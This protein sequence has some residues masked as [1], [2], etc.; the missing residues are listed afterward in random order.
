[1]ERERP[2]EIPKGIEE[3]AE[4]ELIE[5]RKE[6]ARL[7]KLKKQKEK[8]K[9]I[10]PQKEGIEGEEFIKTEVKDD[11]I[12]SLEE[13]FIKVEDLLSTEL[14]ELDHKT[15]EKYT[16]Q[17]ESELKILEEEILGEEGLLEKELTTYEKL[18]K[19]YPWLRGK[20]EIHVYYA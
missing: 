18:L 6:L 1:M 15:I 7:R 5:L 2:K 11:N 14:G 10:E 19:A 8:L 17:I 12:A 20:E 4:K 3:K 13:D 9:Q 16:K